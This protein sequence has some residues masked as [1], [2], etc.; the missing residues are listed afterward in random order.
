MFSA[1][2]YRSVNNVENDVQPVGKP[3]HVCY[4]SVYPRIAGLC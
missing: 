1:S 3:V 2:M 4:P